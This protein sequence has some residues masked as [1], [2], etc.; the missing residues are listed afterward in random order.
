[1][2][3]SHTGSLKHASVELRADREVVVAAVK[4]DGDA[5]EYASEELRADPMLLSWSAVVMTPAPG[6]CPAL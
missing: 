2:D 1:M 4:Q 3:M 5:L 6:R